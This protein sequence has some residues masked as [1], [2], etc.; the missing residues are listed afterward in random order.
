VTVRRQI[1][2]VRRWVP[3]LLLGVALAAIPT[4]WITSRQPEMHE[5]EAIL[6]PEQLLPEGRPDF[7]EISAAGLTDLS[8]T[9]AFLA[10][11]PELLAD[12]ARR[13]GLEDSSGLGRRVEAAVDGATAS[14]TVTA[15]G[16]EAEDAVALA[17]AVAES[18]AERSSPPASNTA[19]LLE[20]VEAARERLLVA[21]EAFLQLLDQALPR[22]EAQD[23]ELA[24]RLEQLTELRATYATLS[25][26]LNAPPEG[27]VVVQRADP[28]D[29]DQIAP[30]APYFT[31]LGAL[32][33]LFAAAAIAFL[34]EYLDD[35]VGT[36]AQ[37]RALTGL[38]TLGAIGRR[39][40]LARRRKTYRLATL[41][42]PRS[43]MAE[44]F[45][46]VRANLELISGPDPV[47]TVVVTASSVSEGKT[48]T[49]ANLAGAYAQA[50]RRVIL[51]DADLRR[52]GLHELF[53]LPNSQGLTSLLRDLG[54]GTDH[55]AHTISQQDNLR[56]VTSGPVPQDPSAIL[57]SEPMRELMA[58]F[59]TEADVIV[60]DTPAVPTAVDAA[61]LGSRTDATILVIDAAR[62]HRDAVLE[63]S[64][65]LAGARARVLGTVL[66]RATSSSYQLIVDDSMPRAG[67]SLSVDPSTLDG[68]DA[69]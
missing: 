14:L 56:V 49:A 15:L 10:T 40:P 25:A 21:E 32:A 4:Y 13:L 20:D 6:M 52:P 3:L 57:G 19:A 37:V 51:V 66:Y 27:L 36:A 1:R 65:V 11:T 35:R 33:G 47:H 29:A 50:G 28:R 64:D 24:R 9:W 53:G 2:T 43:S 48:I 58:R 7:T 17:N 62:S 30:R 61:V 54:V 46:T 67:R 16:S 69:A 59:V 39:G 22:T 23:E 38:P 5:A 34:L 55:V 60:L 8:T 26:T 68:T 44:A 63:A 12:V 41:L 31:T 18:I 45:R 42:D